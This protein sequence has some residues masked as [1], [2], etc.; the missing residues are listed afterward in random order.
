MRILI[1]FASRYPLQSALML[2]ALLLAGIVEG[3]GLTALMPLLG[4]AFSSQPQAAALQPTAVTGNDAGVGQAVTRV[5]AIFGLEPGAGVLLLVI[6]VA[7][8][9]KSALVLVAQK[10][11]GYTVAQVATEL[12]LSLLRALLISR[13][14]YFLRQPVGSLAN[15]MA[16]EAMRAANAYLCGALMTANLIQ[17]L[18]YIVIAL[19]ISWR[20]T[21]ACSVATWATV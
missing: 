11:V 18:V 10:R 9:L 2:L 6:V 3:F 16:T 1:T 17:A 12:R 5:L 13:W 15:A 7:I 4:M 8:A 14:E 20:A 21:L 19:M